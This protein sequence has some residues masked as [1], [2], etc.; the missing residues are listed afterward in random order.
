MSQKLM[1]CIAFVSLI[2]GCLVNTNWAADPSLIGH[3]PL[4]GDTL[5]YSGND[6]HGT[7]VGNE[8]YVPG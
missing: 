4:D 3:W 1:F 6:F 8:Q 7:V 5:D 2:L